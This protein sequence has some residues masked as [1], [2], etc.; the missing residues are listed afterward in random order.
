[1]TTRL[2]EFVKRF[3]T[4]TTHYVSVFILVS[5]KKKVKNLSYNTFEYIGNIKLRQ[6]KIII[7]YDIKYY[8][9]I[10]KYPYVFTVRTIRL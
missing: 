7:I 5:R 2:N 4:E 1:M 10:K 9:H 8:V 3:R 6:L